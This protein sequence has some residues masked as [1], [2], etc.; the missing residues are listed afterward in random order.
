[1]GMNHPTGLTDE[2]LADVAAEA[3]RLVA[4][5]VDSDAR[6]LHR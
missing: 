6:G 1:M 4:A 3:A 5:T 2:Q